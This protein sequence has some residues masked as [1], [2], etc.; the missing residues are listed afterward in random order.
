LEVKPSLALAM[1]TGLADHA[2]TI[3]E[4]MGFFG[5]IRLADRANLQKR[6][7]NW[8]STTVPM[9]QIDCDNFRKVG[10]GFQL[11]DVTTDGHRNFVKLFIMRI[12]LPLPR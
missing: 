5:L 3:N 12:S 1:E 8:T 4:I 2:W 11:K 6:K 10:G 7:M 9:W